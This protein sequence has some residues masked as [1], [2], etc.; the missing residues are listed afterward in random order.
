MTGTLAIAVFLATAPSVDQTLTE[1]VAEAPLGF[2]TDAEYPLT[3]EEA[4]WCGADLSAHCPTFKA[5]CESGNRAVQSG[6]PGRYST[7]ERTRG[8][9]SDSESS[10]STEDA[11]DG[12]GEA[13]RSVERDQKKS[14][15]FD[16]PNLAGFAEVFFWLIIIAFGIGLL[17]A[18]YHL[19][20]G[21]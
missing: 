6:L 13:N 14:D 8:S 4:R 10:T 2:C 11:P 16:W 15:D 17:V 3:A 7:R 18:L 12:G 1:I 9:G 20:R 19:R 21:A 5:A